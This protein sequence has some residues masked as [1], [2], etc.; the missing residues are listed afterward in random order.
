MT[1]VAG[2]L[3]VVCLHLSMLQFQMVYSALTHE[4]PMIKSKNSHCAGAGAIVCL[5]IIWANCKILHPTSML[6]INL[7]SLSPL[8]L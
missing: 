2:R 1:H 8:A 4:D 7:T 5:I 6:P 3:Q